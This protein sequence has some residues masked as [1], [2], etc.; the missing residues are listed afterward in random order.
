M[1][2]AFQPGIGGSNSL[3]PHCSFLVGPP[4]FRHQ[5]YRYRSGCCEPALNVQTAVCPYTRKESGVREATVRNAHG[6]RTLT[7]RVDNSTVGRAA[8]FSCWSVCGRHC[9]FDFST[10]R[11]PVVRMIPRIALMFTM[12]IEIRVRRRLCSQ[13][14][15][16]GSALT[17]E[18]P[19]SSGLPSTRLI[20]NR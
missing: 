3:A 12:G 20:S 7:A 5:V 15:R 16:Q 11:L 2:A 13:S 9:G 8:R 4:T 19:S 14:R 1:E 17:L 6:K 10:T 18:V